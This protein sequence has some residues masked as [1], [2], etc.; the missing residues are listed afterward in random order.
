MDGPKAN[1]LLRRTLC[2]RTPQCFASRR[3]R[4]GEAMG[5][6]A[7]GRFQRASCAVLIANARPV[8]CARRNPA[9]PLFKRARFKPAGWLVDAG[10]DGGGCPCRRAP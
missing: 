2:S 9:D 10:L 6:A 8:A 7:R 1:D 5:P 4:P 3:H